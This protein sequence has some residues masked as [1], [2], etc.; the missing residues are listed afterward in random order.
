MKSRRKNLLDASV[1]L[2]QALIH[3][4]K[5]FFKVFCGSCDLGITSNKNDSTIKTAVL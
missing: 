4:P 2:M 3:S 5:Q 1:V